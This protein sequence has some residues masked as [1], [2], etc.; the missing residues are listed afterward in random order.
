MYNQISYTCPKNITSFIERNFPNDVTHIYCT[1]NQIKSFQYLPGSV[2]VI[3]CGNNQINFF[4]YLPGSVR[5]INCD[6]N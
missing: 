1:N 2:R 6:N 4:Q 5:F 3:Y